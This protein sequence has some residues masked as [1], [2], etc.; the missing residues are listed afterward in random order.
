MSVMKTW[1]GACV[2]GDV[3]Q[4]ANGMEPASEVDVVLPPTEPNVIQ[5]GSEQPVPSL[6]APIVDAAR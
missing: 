4:P 5:L 3:V 6:V 2:G 1:P